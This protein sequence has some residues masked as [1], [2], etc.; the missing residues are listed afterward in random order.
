VSRSDRDRLL[1]VL[2]AGAAVTEH[3]QR[4]PLSD[5]LVFDAVRVRLIEIGEAV[6]DISVE[7][8][9]QQPAIPGGRSPPCATSSHTAAS[10]PRTPSSPRPW[11]PTSSN[12]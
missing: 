7:L 3:L 1:D 10:T 11:A 4:E 6:K 5:G 8:L 9:G 2:E 12:C